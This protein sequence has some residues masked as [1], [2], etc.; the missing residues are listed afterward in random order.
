MYHGC[1]LTS[2]TTKITCASFASNEKL[3]SA[4]EIASE[5]EEIYLCKIHCYK[6]HLHLVIGLEKELEQQHKSVAY[7]SK[8]T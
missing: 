7:S 6:A 1:T 4:G 3:M 2:A 5:E 8:Q